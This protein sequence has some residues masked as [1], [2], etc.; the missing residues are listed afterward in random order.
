LSH[1]CVAPEG[2]SL[3]ALMHNVS[4]IFFVVT[5]IITFPMTKDFCICHNTNTFVSVFNIIHNNQQWC[6]MCFTKLRKSYVLR[7]LT[8]V[9]ALYSLQ[10]TYVLVRYLCSRCMHSAYQISFDPHSLI[11]CKY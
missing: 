5:V 8:I 9:A 11:L 3:S 2:T 10:I 1:S 4:S 7:I 6:C